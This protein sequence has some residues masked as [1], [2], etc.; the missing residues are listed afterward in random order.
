MDLKVKEEVH[1]NTRLPF[2]ES[3]QEHVIDTILATQGDQPH[4]IS[5][6]LVLQLYDVVGEAIWLFQ[7]ERSEQCQDKEALACNLSSGS[8]F[9]ELSSLPI[10]FSMLSVAIKMPKATRF[11]IF[12]NL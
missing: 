1:H 3:G 2:G 10:S 12:P 7:T 8:Q 4:S 6:L 9:M 5:Y 11:Y